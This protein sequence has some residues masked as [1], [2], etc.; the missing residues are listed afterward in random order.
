MRATT[1]VAAVKG[2]GSG[3]LGKDYALLTPG[4]TSK[5]QAG[6]RYYSPSA[7]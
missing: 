7:Q 3:F 6:L 4:E 5:G 1:D 2:T